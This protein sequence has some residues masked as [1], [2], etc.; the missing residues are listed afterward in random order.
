MREQE[1][2]QGVHLDSCLKA[3]CGEEKAKPS[4]LMPGS[5]TA[6]KFCN[7]VWQ[8]P[9]WQKWNGLNVQR[10][11]RES[12]DS[13]GKHTQALAS[14]QKKELERRKRQDVPECPVPAATGCFLVDHTAFF[15]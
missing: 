1:G 6:S 14:F 7:G 3:K 5:E 2:R 13:Q 4:L 9:A 15:H 10:I 12:S 11:K 8:A